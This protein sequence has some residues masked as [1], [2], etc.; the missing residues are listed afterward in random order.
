LPVAVELSPVGKPPSTESMLL[1]AS[2]RPLP[3]GSGHANVGCAPRNH[4]GAKVVL[5]LKETELKADALALA[6]D[7]GA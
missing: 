1:R 4:E 3:G 5:E 6:V 7:T 2:D